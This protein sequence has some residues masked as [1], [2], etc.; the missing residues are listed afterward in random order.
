MVLLEVQ[1][2]TKRFGGLT[3]V[4]DVNFTVIERDMMG[5]IGPMVPVRPLFIIWLVGF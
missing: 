3:A 4:N 2:L 5:V 1:G